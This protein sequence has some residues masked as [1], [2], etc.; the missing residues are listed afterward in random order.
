MARCDSMLVVA[1]AIAIESRRS[2]VERRW[3]EVWG[4]AGRLPL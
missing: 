4:I 3:K 1:I 2:A